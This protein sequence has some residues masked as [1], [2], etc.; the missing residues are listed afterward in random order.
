MS[1]LRPYQAD[2]LRGVFSAW[3]N[4]GQPGTS[5]NELGGDLSA[6][7]LVSPTGSGKTRMA[8]EVIV[9]ALKKGHRVML[10]AHRKELIEQAKNTLENAGAGACLVESIQTLL[11]RNE[12]PEVDLL[13]VDECHH[14]VADEWKKLVDHY[15]YARILGLTATPTR[16]DEVPLGVTFG[17]MVNAVHYSELLADGYLVDCSVYAPPKPIQ[18][19]A[20]EPLE[21]YEKYASG[22]R[23]FVYVKTKAEASELARKFCDAGFPAAEVTDATPKKLRA[24][25]ISDLKNGELKILVNVYTL[26]EGVDIPAAEFVMLARG[27]GHISMFLQ[28][29]GRVL[30]PFEGKE[31]AVVIDLVGAMRQHGFPTENR[32]WNLLEGKPERGE[33]ARYGVECPQ[34]FAYFMRKPICPHCGYDLANAPKD[35]KTERLI[36]NVEL[37]CYTKQ[38]ASEETK[39]RELMRL[40]ELAEQRGFHAY[41]VQKNFKEKFGVKP[42]FKSVNCE[43]LKLI[44][45]DKMKS[46]NG[47]KFSRRDHAV[48]LSIFGR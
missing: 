2:A 45:I 15:A 16:L 40:V 3:R 6:V 1:S 34:C 37:Q 41:F 31:R 22:K 32:Y 48:Y 17:S 20:L 13:V 7:C 21:A 36:Y 4:A 27:C 8:V 46:K 5:K 18:G 23:G 30:R 14:I 11:S 28:I 47:G 9:K 19:L 39:Q 26:T 12:R 24:Q 25:R 10:I 38:E 29:V 44:T 33:V 42:N 35:E 43:R